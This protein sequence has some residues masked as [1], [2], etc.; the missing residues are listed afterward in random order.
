VC[1]ILSSSQ[2]KDNEARL[3][4]NPGRVFDCL[5]RFLEFG[6]DIISFL[7]QLRLLLHLLGSEF[8]STGPVSIILCFL[9]LISR[10]EISNNIWSKGLFSCLHCVGLPDISSLRATGGQSRLLAERGFDQACEERAQS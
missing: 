5:V 8:A 9:P 3:N 4:V 10:N 2:V 6:K 7:L 1:R